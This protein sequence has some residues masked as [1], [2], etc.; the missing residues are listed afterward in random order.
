MQTRRILSIGQCAADHYRITRTFQDH[1][2][3]EVLGAD[4]E[5]ESAQILK[6]QDIDLILVNR[7]LDATGSS[8][9]DVIMS[10]KKDSEGLVIPMMLVSNYEDAQEDAVKL[11]AIK[12]FGKA[13]LGQPVMLSVVRRIL[14]REKTP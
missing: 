4:N 7:V 11:G 14:E 3:A 13:A 8:G 2:A 1:F 6:Q 10:L 5:T 12:G 9:L